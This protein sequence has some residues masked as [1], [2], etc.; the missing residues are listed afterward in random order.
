MG[1][2]LGGLWNCAAHRSGVDGDFQRDRNGDVRRT[3]NESSDPFTLMSTFH[4]IYM[5]IIALAVVC[6]VVGILADLALIGNARNARTLA[7]APA[8]FSVSE[9]PV[10]TTLRIYTMVDLLARS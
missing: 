9:I 1:S 3:A 2:V 8:F 5:A 10:G 7:L 6:G 4:F